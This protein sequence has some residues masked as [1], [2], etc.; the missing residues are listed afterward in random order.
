MKAFKGCTNP[1]CKAY[2]KM[3]YKKDNSFCL[4]C[5]NPLSFV[6]AE[7]WKPMESGKEK[8]C[9][10]CAAKRDQHRAEKWDMIKKHGSKAVAAVGTVAVAMPELTKMSKNIKEVVGTISQTVLKIKK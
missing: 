10:S 5:G 9:I 4:S 7:C 1:G 8:F 2:K 6:C 3:H